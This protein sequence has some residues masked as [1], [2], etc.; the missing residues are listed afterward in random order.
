MTLEGTWP[1]GKK[2]KMTRNYMRSPR[3]TKK[4]GAGGE[5]GAALGHRTQRDPDYSNNRRPRGGKAKP[6]FYSPLFLDNEPA[7]RRLINIDETTG[8]R[9][10]RRP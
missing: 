9:A 7:I 5:G 8:C 3:T 4:N 10:T 2:S 1:R 6:A